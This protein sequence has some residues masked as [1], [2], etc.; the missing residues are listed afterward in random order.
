MVYELWHKNKNVLSVEYEPVTNRFGKVL[1]IYDEKHIPVGIQN[2]PNYNLSQGL[3][4]W[5]QS[6]LIPK[7]RSNFKI[8]NPDIDF[9]L[10]GSNGF[11]LS[12]QYWI[13]EEK[14]DMTWE[15]GNFYTNPFNEDIGEY[16][17]GQGH[18]NLQNMTSRS[19]DL[20]SNGQQDKRW[21]IEKGTRFLVKYGRPP[22]YEQPFNEM[23]ASEICRRLDIPYVQYTLLIKGKTE[24]VI[25]SMCPCFVNPDT[26]FVP[27]GFIQYGRE[28]K[29]QVSN[30]NH[31]IECCSQYNIQKKENIEKTFMQMIVLDYIIANTDRHYGNFGFLRNAETLEW[32]G[33]APNFDTGNAMFYEYPTSDLRKSTAIMENVISRSFVAK[34]KEQAEKFSDNIAMLDVDF[35]KLDGIKD[36][37]EDLLSRNPKEDAERIHLLSGLLEKRIRD[38]QEIVYSKNSVSKSFIQIISNDNSN[39]RVMD[40]INIARKVIYQ[41]N[42]NDGLLVDKYLKS[43]KTKTL[44][45]FELKIQTEINK[46]VKKQQKKNLRNNKSISDDDGMSISD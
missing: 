27:A 15:K 23:L 13:K 12:D 1:E 28:K 22:Y 41:N 9:L 39:L 10:T 20:F 19:P 26:E 35:K 14:S 38:F 5:W 43:I 17:T 3:Q 24:P 40:K 21:V 6:R 42:K 4:F 7:N 46:S 31:L 44:E 2:I 32:I 34:Q 33:N 25:Y 8:N 29:R 16:I 11:N 30:Y 36:Y 37:Y 45:E 18:Y